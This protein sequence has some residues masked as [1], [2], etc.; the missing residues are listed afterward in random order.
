LNTGAGTFI[1]RKTKT[2]KKTYDRF[3]FYTPTELARD[4]AFPFKENEK[5]HY[6]IKGQTIIIT[7]ATRTEN[8]FETVIKKQNNDKPATYSNTKTKS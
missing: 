5:V 4:T 3:F 8:A 2:A 7:K 1:N 6:E